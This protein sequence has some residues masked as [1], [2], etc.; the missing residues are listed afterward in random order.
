MLPCVYRY[1]NVHANTVLS[2][3]FHYL[4]S[5]QEYNFECINFVLRKYYQSVFE[6][7]SVYDTHQKYHHTTIK[8]KSLKKKNSHGK[9]HIHMQRKQKNNL[10]KSTVL[11]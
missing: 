10:I 1:V 9:H 7:I 2:L 5:N 4:I 6:F 11:L 3:H 8:K